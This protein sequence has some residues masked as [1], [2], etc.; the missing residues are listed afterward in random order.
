LFTHILAFSPGFLSARG[1]QGSPRIFVSHG[2]RDAIL[3]ID[4]CSRVIVPVLQRRGYNVPFRE[5][6]G[7]HTV[8]PEVAAEGMRWAAR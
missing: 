2:T 3:P 8:P 6:D 7:G 1:Q 4:R 5:F